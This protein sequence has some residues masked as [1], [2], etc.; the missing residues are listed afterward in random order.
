MTH[1]QEIHHTSNIAEE[2]VQQGLAACYSLLLQLA[3]TDGGSEPH[4]EVTYDA[5]TAEAD[6]RGSGCAELRQLQLWPG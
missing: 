6:R 3:T 5:P 4:G 1:V 2:E